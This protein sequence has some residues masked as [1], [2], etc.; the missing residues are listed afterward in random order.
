MAFLLLHNYTDFI[1]KYVYKY[2]KINIDFIKR[3]LIQLKYLI[4]LEVSNENYKII[5]NNFLVPTGI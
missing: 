5:F 1:Q 3:L 4:I 2:I